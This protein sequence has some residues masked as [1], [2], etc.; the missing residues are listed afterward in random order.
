MKRVYLNLAA[1]AL[2]DLFNP[3][4]KLHALIGPAAA[5]AV[6][7]VIVNIAA[8]KTIARTNPIFRL[9]F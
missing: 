5:G 1:C 8:T 2:F 9:M 3:P 4:F 6:F 7:T